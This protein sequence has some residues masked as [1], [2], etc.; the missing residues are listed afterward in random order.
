MPLLPI[1]VGVKHLDAEA[2]HVLGAPAHVLADLPR[3]ERNHRG[4]KATIEPNQQETTGTRRQQQGA[5]LTHILER[6]SGDPTPP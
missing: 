1:D 3:R 6:Y 4:S 2:S 5:L